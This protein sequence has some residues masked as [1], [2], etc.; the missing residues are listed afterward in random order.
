MPNNTEGIATPDNLPVWKCIC[1]LSGFHTRTIYDI[2]WCHETDLIATACG[3]DIIR[4]FKETVDSKPH[5]PSFELICTEHGAH[6]QD[7][8]AVRWNPKVTKQLVSCSDD[9][10]IKVWNFVE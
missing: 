5:D 7:V 8:N 9:G 4:I 10:D 2:S 3:D 1:T 6:S